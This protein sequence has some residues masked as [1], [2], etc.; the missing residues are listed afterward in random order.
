MESNILKAKE[1]YITS[2]ILEEA[3]KKHEG[4]KELHLDTH[5][6]FSNGLYVRQLDIP[7]G[8]VI[9]G[10][11][12]RESTLNI[13]AK[14]SMVIIDGN[15]NFT[16]TAPYTFT[17]E[18]YSKKSAYALEDCSFINVHITDSKNVDEIEEKVIISDEEFDKLLSKNK[19]DMLCLGSL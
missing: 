5:H 1:D 8:I 16:I 6:H 9:V 2:E 7:K 15:S 4:F 10:K 18:P 17:S 13:L 3:I 11:R 19:E 14:G 12:H